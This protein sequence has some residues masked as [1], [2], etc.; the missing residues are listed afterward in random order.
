M[1]IITDQLYDMFFCI[2]IC[3]ACQRYFR[4]ILVYKDFCFLGCEMTMRIFS[5]HCQCILPG[6]NRKRNRSV[7]FQFACQ[8]FFSCF[9]VLP[10][11]RNIRV[12]FILV[13]DS[14]ICTDI[15]PFKLCGRD[16]DFRCIQIKVKRVFNGVWLTGI[17]CTIG[18]DHTQIPLSFFFRYTS[19]KDIFDF[20]CVHPLCRKYRCILMETILNI[21]NTTSIIFQLQL[22]RSVFIIDDCLI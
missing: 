19:H 20:F 5:T 3:I 4:C 9:C 14:D 1:L 10:C 2:S 16:H 15:I 8:T 13:C 11:V 21:R 18:T 6:N 7:F 12:C 22:Y 17:P